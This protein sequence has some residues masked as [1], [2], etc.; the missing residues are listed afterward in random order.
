MASVAGVSLADVR[1]EERSAVMVEADMG[2]RLSLDVGLVVAFVVVVVVETENKEA[3]GVSGVIVETA[4]AGGGAAIAEDGSKDPE[5]C[6]P[7]VVN[8]PTTSLTELDVVDIR[9]MLVAAEEATE[10]AE[11][12]SPSLTEDTTSLGSRP[13]NLAERAGA[14]AEAG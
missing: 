6:E 14:V 7:V 4:S 2:S 1:G 5:V 12:A 10:V 11:M 9:D 3:T 8:C 13:G